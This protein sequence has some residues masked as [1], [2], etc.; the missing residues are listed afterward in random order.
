MAVD[1]ELERRLHFTQIDHSARALLSTLTATVE[2]ALSV[3]L[4]RFYN[5]IRRTPQVARFF[6]NE[7]HIDAA[8]GAQHTHWM[9]IVRGEFS[10]TYRASVQRIGETH[11]RIGLEPSWYI[12]GYAMILEQLILAVVA[13]DQARKKSAFGKQHLSDLGA[14]IAVL[15][16][17]ALI[18]MDMAISVYLEKSENARREVERAAQE[19]SERVVAQIG[20]GLAALAGGDVTYRL[21]DDLPPE[22][23]QLQLDF[24]AAMGRMENALQEVAASVEAIR[25]GS[26]EITH[27]ADDLSR[28]TEQQAAALE[29]TAAALDQITATVSRTASNARHADESVAATRSEAEKSSLVMGDAVKAMQAIEGSSRQVAQIIGVIDEIAFQTNLL[30]LNAGVE[31]ARAGEA[32]RGFAVVAS[33]VR[34]LAQRSAEA[35]KEIKQLIIAST[36]QVEG[37]VALVGQGREALREIMRR[38]EQVSIVVREIA[39]TAQEQSLGLAQ[40]NQAVNQMDTTTQQNAAMVEQST[41]ASHAM[42][43]EA[44][45]LA[46]LVGRFRVSAARA[47]REAA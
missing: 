44:E 20:K 21:T 39:S 23:K 45:Q 17:A 18:D 7:A 22:Y 13:E 36:D 3:G 2:Q 6:K 14:R 40:V 30:A 35:A 42:A 33:E 26:G 32:G 11:A 31:A 25:S 34:A 16:K 29:E 37:G 1:S 41:A 8:K 4:D 38:V 10:E 27:A 9:T 43:Q 28:R 5:Q 19:K 24:N 12:G 15:T 47:L 46:V